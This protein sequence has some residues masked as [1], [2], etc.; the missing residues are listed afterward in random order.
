[1]NEN[2]LKNFFAI[3]IIIFLILGANS[4]LAISSPSG[5]SPCPGQN[6]HLILSLDWNDV[7]GIHH[8]ELYYKELDETDWTDRYP[9]VSQYT[10]TGLS[11][12]TDYEWFV[13]SCGDPDCAN[14]ANSQICSFDTEDL[15][16]P[17]DGN[18]GGNGGA[19]VDLTKPL[20][21]NTLEELLNNLLDFLFFLAMA[22]GPLLIIYGAFLIL[23]AAGN[24]EKVNKGKTIILWTLIKEKR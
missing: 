20:K 5:L 24:A 22:L 23:T 6:V 18:G 15:T 16:P 8:Y 11:P 2:F 10:I 13:V 3:V 14:S 7:S 17:S 4:S 1:M 19:P 9:S 12:S 21:A